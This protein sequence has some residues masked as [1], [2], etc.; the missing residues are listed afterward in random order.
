M[1]N[2]IQIP[3][4]SNKY[5]ENLFTN[6]SIIGDD[7][8][9]T[10]SG[11]STSMATLNNYQNYSSKSK[12]FQVFAVQDVTVGFDC[13]WNFGDSLKATAVQEGTY[14]FQF[15]LLVNDRNANVGTLIDLEVDVFKNGL[16]FETYTYSL[17]PYSMDINKYYHFAQNFDVNAGVELDFAFR[18]VRPS[19][20]IP[21]PNFTFCFDAFQ[22]N[23]DNINIGYGAPAPYSLPLL[24]QVSGVYDVANTLSALSFTGTPIKITNNGAGTNTNLDY[25]L[26]GITNLLDTSD[27]FLK[28]DNLSLGDKVDV[29]CDLTVTTTTAN[30]TVDV[31]LDVALGTATNYKIYLCRR[32]FKTAGTY[33][34]NDIS[35]WLYLGN[36]D[37]RDYDTAIMFHSDANATVLNNGVA[38]SVTKRL[39]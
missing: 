36:T 26:R 31:Y 19:I 15:G 12:A 28:F 16:L 7:T 32:T 34:I 24:N 6:A 39:V 35:N 30:Q 5:K 2:L 20:G 17:N 25:G 1:A 29:R 9:Y 22:L 38:I 23:F 10:F 3:S 33:P 8:A 37:T 4:F 11:V 27:S 14:V 21:N 13:S 18:L